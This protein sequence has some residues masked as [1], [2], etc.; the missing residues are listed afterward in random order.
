MSISRLLRPRS[1]AIVGA[2]ATAGSLGGGVLA[3][4]ERFRFGGALHLVNPRYDRIGDRP[5]FRSIA[6]LPDGI[7]CAVLA[8]PHAHVVDS[9]RA[10]AEKG[11]GGLIVLAGGFA[12]AGEEGKNA[13]EQIAAT[14]LGAGVA[15]QGPNCL[16]MINYVD[17]VPLMFGVAPF[18]ALGDRKGVAV[19]SQSGAM[20]S[21]V[22]PANR[23][24]AARLARAVRVSGWSGPRRFS[25]SANTC[26]S[27]AMASW[28]RPANR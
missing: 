8:I 1:V 23:Y 13:Q 27:I 26:S 28:T 16:G 7:D 11:I 9:V 15:L 20:A 25:R 22:R 3:N 10:C 17:G 21:A 24:E 12:E 4:L 19:V 14:A 18:D 2:S 6:E 5:C